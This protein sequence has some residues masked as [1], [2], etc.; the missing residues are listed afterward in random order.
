VLSS[1]K[2]RA[3]YNAEG[4]LKALPARRLR[5]RGYWLLAHRYIGIF[6]GL[7]FVVLG[8][9]G[10]INVFRWEIDALINPE[11]QIAQ[12]NTAILPLG[13]IV[14]AAHRALPDCVGN[15]SLQLPAS[16]ASP[17][18]LRCNEPERPWFSLRMVWVNPYTAEVVSS[19]RFGE[20]FSTWVYDLHWALLLGKNGHTAVGLLGLLLMFSLASGV[21]LWWPG[22]GKLAKGLAIKRR[23]SV[24]RLMFD[25]HKSAGLY[26]L[27]VLFILAFSG[28]YLVFPASVKP[29]V[30]RIAPLTLD[31]GTLR[32]QPAAGAAPLSVD[33]ALALAGRVFPDGEPKW[34]NLPS[35]PQ[36]VYQ[37]LLRRPEAG[38]VE[39]FNRSY[40]GSAVVLDQYSGKVLALR[41]SITRTAGDG[42]LDVQWAFH[43]GEALGL[44]GRILWC[45]VG[46]VPLA[47]YATGLVRWL[48]KRRARS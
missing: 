3:G 19:R 7:V 16:A 41:D 45:A 43:Y 14:A 20:F 36:G 28:T 29:L 25:W 34:I 26:A 5:L 40:G 38:L 15:W 1:I 37:V 9:T 30:H 18:L 21:Y 44:P 32:S 4:S 48:Q 17:A 42:F 10:S 12:P 6:A 31:A 24:E 47:L 8:L 46:L 35:G 27:P 23:A 13:E 22:W 33:E 39:W 11:L 2:D